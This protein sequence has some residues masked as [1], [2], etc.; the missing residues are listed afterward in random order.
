M[1]SKAL[2]RRP[3]F[4]A[5]TDAYGSTQGLNPWGV[6]PPGCAPACQPTVLGNAGLPGCGT[7]TLPGSECHLKIVFR[8]SGSVAALTSVQFEVLAGRAGAFKPRSVYMVGISADDPATN[9]RF[10]IDN[11]TVMGAPQLVSF[12]GATITTNRGL[13]DFFNLQCMPQ[14][15]DWA[16]FGSSAG[17]GLQFSVTNLDP[18]DAAVLYVSVWGD[19][20]DT[21]LIGQS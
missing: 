6:T 11:I 7:G 9:V 16:V 17:Q 19:A 10:S 12:D 1:Q 8:N 18:N 14:P 15:V 21:T 5:A 4:G 3:H 2:S 20:A 13:T